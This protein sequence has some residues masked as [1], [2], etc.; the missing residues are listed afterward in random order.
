MTTQTI[1]NTLYNY[2]K[3]SK[4]P[5]KLRRKDIPEE[6]FT[7]KIPKNNIKKLKISKNKIKKIDNCSFVSIDKG[8]YDHKLHYIIDGHTH[9]KHCIDKYFNE[10]PDRSPVY[11]LPTSKDM[12]KYVK[13]SIINTKLFS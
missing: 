4:Y 9:P 7:F 6:S 13:E 5:K 3:N 2:I 8:N 10:I 12:E 11:C 1:F